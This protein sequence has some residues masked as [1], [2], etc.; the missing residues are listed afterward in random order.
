MCAYLTLAP[1]DLCV[2][3]WT[4]QLPTVAHRCFVIAAAQ[5]S[6]DALATVNE[7]VWT[8]MKAAKLHRQRQ[9]RRFLALDV[10]TDLGGMLAR[11]REVLWS[12]FTEA[13]SVPQ[14]QA[15]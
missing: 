6:F 9:N 13:S 4:F 5:A 11:R 8:R 15:A 10:S 7:L 1:R 14:T 3:I 12:S 2:G